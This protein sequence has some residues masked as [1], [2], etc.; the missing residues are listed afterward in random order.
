MP[1][2]ELA[3]PSGPGALE[4]Q[5]E[6][7]A[8]ALATQ[9]VGGFRTRHPWLYGI[10]AFVIGAGV[11][12]LFIMTAYKAWAF[13]T[14]DLKAALDRVVLGGLGAGLASVALAFGYAR[15]AASR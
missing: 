3:G 11:A 8:I 2:T 13:E 1:H 6:A 5:A 15:I 12:A 4:M 7:T 9:G 10:A 14:I